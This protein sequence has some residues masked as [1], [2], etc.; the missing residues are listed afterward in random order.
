[1]PFRQRPSP[2]GSAGPAAPFGGTR[3]F[4]ERHFR[5]AGAILLLVMAGT[6]FAAMQSETV[7]N[8]E[9]YHILNG[10]AY[11]KTGR[12]PLTTEHPPLGELLPALPLLFLDL[13]LPGHPVDLPPDLSEER[14][15]EQD[16]LFNNRRSASTI[17]LVARSVD[18]LLTMLLGVLVLW[19]TWRHFGAIPALVADMLLAFDPNF[20][21]NG[22][23]A[24]NDVP[25]TLC[26]V[27]GILCWNAFLADR[28]WRTAALCGALTGIAVVTKYNAVLLLPIYV[29]LYLVRWWQAAT[30]E[31][32]T[33][34][35]FGRLLK[36]L[37]LLCAA[38]FVVVWA[39]FGFE[40][41]PWLPPARMIHPM[42]ISER[43]ALDPE[44]FGRVGHWLQ[45]HPD[46]IA[47]T[48]FLLQRMP[49][50]MPS[51]FRGLVMLSEHQIVGHPTYFLGMYSTGG[52]WYYFPV[53]MAVKTPTGVLILFLLAVTASSL[54]LFRDGLRP[55]AD[56]LQKL[57]PDWYALAIPTSFYFAICLRAHINIGI[58][59]VLPIYPLVFIWC[60]AMLFSD[61]IAMPVLLRRA[62]VICLLL[63]SVESLL[64]FP[65]YLGFF[66]TVSG[67]PRM[68]WKY[69]VD[70]NMDL[71]QDLKKLPPYLATHGISNV[72][73]AYFGAARLDYYGIQARPVPS[74]VE[75]ARQ[76]GCVVVMSM[77]QLMFD[78]DQKGRYR[79]LERFAPTDYVGSS[80]RV[81]DLHRY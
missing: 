9:G 50:P 66:N 43:L 23:Y 60:A 36:S 81:Y 10:Y 70:S 37:L 75:E 25:V 74:S 2:N 18:I 8:D 69:V 78:R 30:P 58:R 52:W 55:V 53:V 15:R 5:G 39:V 26:F 46:S 67:G 62:S 48:E 77:T 76:S 16:F 12:L 44:S 79:W 64:A 63:V 20:I 59:H 33:K 71:G 19:W 32:R 22:H 56:K 24:I 41:E 6:Q 17:L 65:D 28:R 47:T 80:Y 3:S 42:S 4:L 40:T 54:I 1:M 21:A 38:S 49:I 31:A 7:A 68:G 11:L 29:L 35:S 13:Q 27:G 14:A 61:R 34:Y 57:H 45:R 51:L 72:C 73:L